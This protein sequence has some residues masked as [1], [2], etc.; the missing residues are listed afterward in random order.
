VRTPVLPGACG[1]TGGH[2]HLVV[3]NCLHQ[4]VLELVDRQALALLKDAAAV[5][6]AKCGR[7]HSTMDNAVPDGLSP[8]NNAA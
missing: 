3:D 1:T 5:L 4:L 6:D 8:Q 2:A 7:L